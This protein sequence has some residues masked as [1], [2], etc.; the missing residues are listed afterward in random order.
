MKW[1]SISATGGL[2]WDFPVGRTG[3]LKLRPIFNFMLGR[4]TTDAAILGRLI[5]ASLD[6]SVEVVQDAKLNAYGLGG[7]LMLDYEHIVRTTRSTWELRYSN[8]QLR[9]FEERPRN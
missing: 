3:E 1:N 7:S 6:R 8:I 9:T 2:G 5:G 4:T